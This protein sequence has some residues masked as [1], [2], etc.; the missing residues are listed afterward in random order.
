ME[1][2]SVLAAA[3]AAFAFGA[4]WYMSMSRA[5]IAAAEIPVG[6]DG[7]PQGGG[8]MPFVVGILAMILVAGMMR[9]SFVTSGVTSVGG[10]A[11]AGLGIGAFLIT[12]WVAMNYAFSMRKPGL[13]VIDGVNS[14]IGCTLMGAVLNLF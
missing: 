8:A 3:A 6:P 5:W 1:F 4:V 14:V 13:T 7:K 12:P 10:G 9:H 11:V 2:L